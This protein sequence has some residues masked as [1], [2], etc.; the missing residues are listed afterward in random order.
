MTN[1]DKIKNI[2]KRGYELY[3]VETNKAIQQYL[4]IKKDNLIFGCIYRIHKKLYGY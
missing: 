1:E 2:Q 3:K 4:A